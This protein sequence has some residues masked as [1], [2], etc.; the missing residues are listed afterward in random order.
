MG[1]N[2]S[3]LE[4]LNATVQPFAICLFFF[5]ISAKNSKFRVGHR[6]GHGLTQVLYAPIERWQL[7]R[8]SE[9][10]ISKPANT[11]RK[12]LFSF[13][14]SRTLITTNRKNQSIK[15]CTLHCINQKNNQL[16]SLIYFCNILYL[17]FHYYVIFP[18]LVKRTRKIWDGIT[19]K[20]RANTD[21]TGVFDEQNC[22]QHD[23]KPKNLACHRLSLVISFIQS[24]KG[25]LAGFLCHLHRSQ[26]PWRTDD[27]FF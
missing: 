9:L 4:W 23:T 6:V 19:L 22:F 18:Y 16:H 26:A 3:H 7:I 13:F 8:N 12:S 15:S 24:N 20:N 1:L 10:Y 27:A 25:H 14:Q 5:V 17:L 21:G 11:T 2:Y